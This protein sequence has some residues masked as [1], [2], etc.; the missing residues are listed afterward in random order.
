M[1]E[2][3]TVKKEMSYCFSI[4]VTTAHGIQSIKDVVLEFLVSKS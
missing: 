1:N 2:V 4:T 3:T